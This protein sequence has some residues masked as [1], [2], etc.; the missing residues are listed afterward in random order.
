[1]GVL[2]FI[3]QDVF[4][5]LCIGCGCMIPSDNALCKACE[6]KIAFMEEDSL[7]MIEFK[8]KC[9]LIFNEETEVYALFKFEKGGVGQKLIHALK[10]KNRPIIGFHLS[11][12]VSE[13]I[14]FKTPISAIVPIPLHSKKLKKRGYNQLDIFSKNLSKILQ[15]DYFPEGLVRISDSRAQAGRSKWDR[16]MRQE[17]SRFSSELSRDVYGK[18]LL[19]DDVFTTGNTLSDAY[20]TLHLA[21]FKNISILT[22]ASDI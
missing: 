6:T 8:A 12:F 16:E 19:V 7:E 4:P 1:M 20:Y 10:Y 14:R 2:S 9:A 22:I 18:I 3:L 17:K 11:Y 15:C 21:G 5:Q 13:K